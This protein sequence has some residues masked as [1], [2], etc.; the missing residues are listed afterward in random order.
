MVPRTPGGGSAG[1]T[2]SSLGSAGLRPPRARRRQG[3]PGSRAPAPPAQRARARRGGRHAGG[4]RPCPGAAP[5]LLRAAAAGGS[6]GAERAS[7][8]AVG[9][10]R[11]SALAGALAKGL[12]DGPRGRGKPARAS[13]LPGAACSSCVFPFSPVSVL[14][15]FGRLFRC[16]LSEELHLEYYD[17]K[18]YNWECVSSLKMITHG[19]SLWEKTC[20]QSSGGNSCLTY[21]PTL[22]DDQNAKISFNSCAPKRITK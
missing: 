1:R 8:G 5:V 7:A 11:C 22:G 20:Y 13:L 15:S 12:R 4:S 14:G 9:G 3:H 10:S 6:S 16:L 17:S 2:R 19:D 18:G 21:L